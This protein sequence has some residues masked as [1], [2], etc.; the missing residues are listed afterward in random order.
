MSLRCWRP[1]S[2]TAAGLPSGWKCRPAGPVWSSTS[3]CCSALCA[4]VRLNPDL[5]AHAS[6]AAQRPPVTSLSVS[7]T[8]CEEPGGEGG[9]QGAMWTRG[10]MTPR[11]PC[12]VLQEGIC[13][14]GGH[15][16][17]GSK[18]HCA[19]RGDQSEEPVPLLICEELGK[20][21]MSPAPQH[22]IKPLMKT[23]TVVS[24]HTYS[25]NCQ[26]DQK[27]WTLT[28][29]IEGITVSRCKGVWILVLF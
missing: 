23:L 15:R 25:M 20:T 12:R 28:L 19:V 6:N 21:L 3:G 9:G 17:Q 13:R 24:K 8:L 18:T 27:G 1:P 14:N 11:P 5:A 26:R 29:Y 16:G 4:A 2:P 7:D 22:Q 10:H